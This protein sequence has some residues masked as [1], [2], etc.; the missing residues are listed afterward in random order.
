MVKALRPLRIQQ[1]L[2]ALGLQLQVI[3]LPASTRTAQEA[4]DAVGCRVE[5]IVKSIVFRGQ[6]TDEPV[7][8][9]AGGAGR[10]DEALVGALAGEPIGKADA[11]YVRERTGFAIGGV[12]PVG[13]TA[14][15]RTV[16]DEQ[17]FECDAIWA[18]A[19]TPNSVFQ[20][21]PADLRVLAPT[22]AIGKVK[23]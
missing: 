18:A 7:L 21:R 22:A 2:D 3:E 8:V 4:A 13:S 15:I 12:S 10:I 23:R 9:L 6:R 11:D 5:Q 16:I 1:A 17:L 19:G 14:P 20:L